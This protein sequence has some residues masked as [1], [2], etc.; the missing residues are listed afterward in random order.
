[1]RLKS[2]LSKLFKFL[3]LSLLYT[4][5]LSDNKLDEKKKINEILEKVK[6]LEAEIKGQKTDSINESL[7]SNEDQLFFGVIITLLVFFVTLP[8]NDVSSFLQSI[9]NVKQDIAVSNA[10]YIKYTGIVAFLV[11]TLLRYCAVVTVGRNQSKQ[12]V[13]L[14]K[15]TFKI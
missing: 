5:L 7:R 4:I 1:M 9:F 12:D 13:T 10:G 3:S 14:P 2:R 8:I 15:N 11:S 6:G